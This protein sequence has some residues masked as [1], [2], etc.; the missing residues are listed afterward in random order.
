MFADVRALLLNANAAVSHARTNIAFCAFNPAF[1]APA[2]QA[3]PSYLMPQ[4]DFQTA[5]TQQLTASKAMRLSSQQGGSHFQGNSHSYNSNNNNNSR[6]GFSNR[7]K[8]NNPFLN[9]NQ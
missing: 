6:K 3:A 2:P 5:L 4:A 8:S 9:R 1:S 7:N